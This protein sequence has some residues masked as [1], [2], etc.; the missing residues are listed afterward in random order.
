MTKLKDADEGFDSSV[1][2]LAF[3]PEEQ[4]E[5][6]EAM[7]TWIP[8]WR[9]PTNPQEWDKLVSQRYSFA[10]SAKE[11]HDGAV[12]SD[13]PMFLRQLL[14]KSRYVAARKY[15]RTKR[16]ASNEKQRLCENLLHAMGVKLAD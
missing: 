1:C 6:D 13:A 10:I 9:K 15:W 2:S 4:A 3:T 14:A 5:L 16:R 12:A 7:K 11:S 8:F